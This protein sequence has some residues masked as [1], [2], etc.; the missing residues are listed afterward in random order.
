MKTKP[1]NQDNRT[2][3]VLMDSVDWSIY[4]D[5]LLGIHRDA[6]ARAHGR[7]YSQVVYQN[8]VTGVSPRMWRDREGAFPTICALFDV[9]IGQEVKRHLQIAALQNHARYLNNQR[10]KP[11]WSVPAPSEEELEALRQHIRRAQRAAGAQEK[12]V[13][14]RKSKRNVNRAQKPLKGPIG[15]KGVKPGKTSPKNTSNKR[16]K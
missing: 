1:D 16:K 2:D 3:E 10:L 9:V 13:Q 8:K 15:R 11:S 12:T 7:T 6:T 14:P 4:R 5:A